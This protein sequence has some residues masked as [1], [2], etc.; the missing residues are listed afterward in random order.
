MA[1]T[2]RFSYSKLNQYENC[3]YAY[4]DKYVEG[5]YYDVPSLPALFGSLVHKTEEKISH[6]IMDN[7]PVDYD[8]LIKDFRGL[9]LPKRNKYDRDGDLFGTDIL[10]K[11]FPREWNEFSEKSNKNF[12]IKADEYIESGIYRQEKYMKAH[13]ELEIVGVEIGFEYEYRGYIFYGYIDRLLGYREDEKRYELHDIKTKD[14][15]FADKEVASPL[16]HYVYYNYLKSEYGDDIK[17]DHFYDLPIANALQPCMTRG[18][19]ARCEKKLDKLLDGIESKDFRAHP[20]P[21]C[22][23]CNL[24]GLNPRQPLAAKGKCPYYCLWTPQDRRFDSL[25]EWEGEEHHDEIMVKF[26]KMLEDEGK[27]GDNPWAKKFNIEF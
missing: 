23:Y 4:K 22:Y 18:G 6:M 24:G 19:Y 8:S 26:G 9:N 10:S 25:F 21:L 1:K 11:R 13:P 16:Q 14:H 12:A 17:V 5:N 3:P 20:T 7:Q 27:A 15:L 2:E